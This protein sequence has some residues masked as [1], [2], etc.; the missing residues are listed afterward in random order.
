MPSRVGQSKQQ[1]ALRRKGCRA[2]YTLPGWM[3]KAI[4]A[5]VFALGIR[6]TPPPPDTVVSACQN[7]Y[8]LFLRCWNFSK[9][10][11]TLGSRLPWVKAM[12]AEGYRVFSGHMYFSNPFSRPLP[13]KTICP[14]RTN[15][16]LRMSASHLV[17]K[18]HALELP[19]YVP[20]VCSAS[21][22]DTTRHNR[23]PSPTLETALQLFCIVPRPSPCGT[24]RKVLGVVLLFGLFP[25]PAALQSHQQK[26]RTCAP[27]TLPT[28]NCFASF[29]VYPR[30]PPKTVARR[31]AVTAEKATISVR[32]W[33]GG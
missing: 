24:L 17:L 7:M 13:T 6:I 20:L 32:E 29:Q 26:D 1:V 22:I 8:P 14:R 25:L 19:L 30:P 3:S 10:T 5:W 18:H 23:K 33:P 12:K 31:P 11:A 4:H 9:P 28:E 27:G 15:M 2:S 21:Q 16:K